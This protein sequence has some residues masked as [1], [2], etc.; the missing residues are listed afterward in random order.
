MKTKLS[1]LVLRAHA[2]EVLARFYARLGLSFEK[3]RH[4]SGPEHFAALMGE[5]V[6]ELYPLMTDA[7]KTTGTRIGFA[8]ENVESAFAAMLEAGAKPVVAP[9]MSEW[10]L[11]AVVDDPEGHRIELTERKSECAMSPG[12]A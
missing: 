3:H 10:G 11:R 1:L 6:F 9:K 12:A 8:V 4:G 7:D 2:P 5:V